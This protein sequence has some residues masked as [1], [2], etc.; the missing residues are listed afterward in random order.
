MRDYGL[1]GLAF[2]MQRHLKLAV[3]DPL[4]KIELRIPDRNEAV[5]FHIPIAIVRRIE[6]QTE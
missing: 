4:K 2:F 5:I 6:S 1:G 3:G